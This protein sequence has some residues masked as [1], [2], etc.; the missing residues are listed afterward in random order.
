[1]ESASNNRN[2]DSTLRELNLAM[3]STIKAGESER[4][5]TIH[6]AILLEIMFRTQKGSSA[7]SPENIELK[8]GQTLGE[9]IHLLNYAFKE[10]SRLCGIGAYEEAET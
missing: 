4:A 7:N 10:S 8:D 1:M 2:P 3:H 5:H 6:G 9:Y